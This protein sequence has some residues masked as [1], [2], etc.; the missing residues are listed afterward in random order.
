[1]TT[2][3]KATGATGT[4]DDLYQ[5]VAPRRLAEVLH[6]PVRT[7]RAAPSARYSAG[8]AGFFLRRTA[9]RVI[10]QHR[11]GSHAVVAYP[12]PD[13]SHGVLAPGVR[14][15]L[16]ASIRFIALGLAMLQVDAQAQRCPPIAS[17]SGDRTGN[18]TTG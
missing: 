11:P 14:P 7:R 16:I 13:P 6:Q 15:V 10:E 9:A 12:R 5:G 2:A 8:Q 3:V 18:R 4:G 17:E 1:M